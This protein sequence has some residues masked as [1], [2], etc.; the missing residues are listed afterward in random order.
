MRYIYKTKNSKDYNVIEL[1]IFYEIG[2]YSYFT[3]DKKPRCYY[4]GAK[5][6][7]RI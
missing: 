7:N 6:V 4:I 2:G 1:G 3:G 5:P